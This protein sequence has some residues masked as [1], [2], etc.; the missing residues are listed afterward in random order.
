MSS[1]TLSFPDLNKVFPSTET[2]PKPIQMSPTGKPRVL[3]G[4]SDPIYT[5]A[6]FELLVRAGCEVVVAETGTDAIAELRKADHPLVA[7]LD[8]KLSGMNGWEI[9]GRMRDAE[10]IIY[11]ILTGENPTTEEIVTGLES[12][13]DLYLPK[14]IPT[15]QLLAYVNVGVRSGTHHRILLEQRNK[16][17]APA[18]SI[19]G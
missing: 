2:G 8:C 18:V 10:K 6:T 15:G 5:L 3:I 19:N 13:A 4:D 9:C 14:S 11:L 16:W 1:E 12:G 17:D 7:I